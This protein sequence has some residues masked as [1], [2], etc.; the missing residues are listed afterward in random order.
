LGLK[1]FELEKEL[2]AQRNQ[3]AFFASQLEAAQRNAKVRQ[4]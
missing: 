1:V 4:A 2:T 3:A